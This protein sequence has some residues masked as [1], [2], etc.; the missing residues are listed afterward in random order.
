MRIWGR[1]QGSIVVEAAIIMPMLLVFIVTM[2][3]F[4]QIAIKEMALQS[5]VSET[6]KYVAAHMYPLYLLSQS[7]IGQDLQALNARIS[8]GK[9]QWAAWDAVA[10]DYAAIIPDPLLALISGHTVLDEIYEST[11]NAIALL[12]LQYFVDERMLKVEQLSVI[13]SELPNFQSAHPYFG[14]EVRYTYKLLIPF[15]QREIMLHK[16]AYERVWVGN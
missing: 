11:S 10:Q 15:F 9:E 8:E 4:V 13:A 7:E 2:I 1:E 16:S 6:T 5:A 14:M 12:V 3:A